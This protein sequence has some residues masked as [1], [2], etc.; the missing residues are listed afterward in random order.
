M[1]R[2]GYNRA[3]RAATTLVQRQEHT[4]RPGAMCD[5]IYPRHVSRG[6]WGGTQLLLLPTNREMGL[7]PNSRPSP[8]DEFQVWG[9][10]G[11]AAARDA[12]IERRATRP[13]RLEGAHPSGRYRGPSQ[14]NCCADRRLQSGS[15]FHVRAQLLR[16]F[17]SP[18]SPSVVQGGSPCPHFGGAIRCLL[19]CARLVLLDRRRP[20]RLLFGEEG[21][22]RGPVAAP[23]WRTCSSL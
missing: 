13:G 5:R 23:R 4:L 14:G 20:V 7:L 17:S 6:R 12:E 18:S 8:C 10:R 15:F 16:C 3:N 1:I 21:R 2:N 22:S 11:C 9:G 19:F